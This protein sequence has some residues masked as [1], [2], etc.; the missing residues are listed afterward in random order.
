MKQENVNSKNYW[1]NRF[2]TD[3]DKKQGPDQSR[4]FARVTI[5]NLPDWF[6]RLVT[7]EKLSICDW[8]CAAGDGTDLLASCL[9][10]ALVS[11]VDLS[12]HAIK[13]ANSR[14]SDLKFM[15][16]DWTT[17]QESTEKFD[18]IFSS[19]TLEHF[20]NPFEIL[21]QLAAH[22]R[23][24]IILTLPYRELE[25][26][27]EHF[28]TFLS[29]NIP[30]TTA[31]NFSLV[32]SRVIDTRQITPNYWY[33]EQIVLIYA[34]Q[35]SLSSIELNLNSINITSEF[36]EDKL[37]KLS[38]AYKD[39]EL[40]ITYLK[41]ADFEKGIKLNDVSTQLQKQTASHT[42]LSAQ[43]AFS[44]ETHQKFEQ[45]LE[46]R[47]QELATVSQELESVTQNLL[48]SDA[49]KIHLM[50]EIKLMKVS[51]S[52]RWTTPL[53]ADLQAPTIPELRLSATR[54][55][56][57]TKRYWV[58][59]KRDGFRPATQRANAYLRF[60]LATRKAGTTASSTNSSEDQID[61]SYNPYSYIDFLKSIKVH[62]IN[63]SFPKND[64]VEK[65]PFSIIT[66]LLNEA[67]GVSVF[68]ESLAHQTLIPDEIIIVDGGSTDGTIDLIETASKTLKLSVKLIAS[69]GCSI[70]AGRNIAIAEATHPF[71]IVVDAG[72]HLDKNLCNN[73]VGVFSDY[74]DADLVGGVYQ[75]TAAAKSA[76]HFVP[77]WSTNDWQRFLPSSR[78]LLIRKEIWEKTG[79]Y[80]EFLSKTGEDT[81]FDISYRRHSKLWIFNQAAFV[82][83]NGP[84]NMAA[85]LKLAESYGYGDGESG[86]GDER[87]Y[88]DYKHYVASNPNNS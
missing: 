34:N 32:H 79:G 27:S 41:Q 28:F 69:P 85:A 39:K 87:F 38:T 51:R 45:S 54:L 82:H 1:E 26:D 31:Q 33:G 64:V 36:Y 61:T 21:E 43:L 19:N 88:P 59:L 23:Q 5:E 6:K 53:R 12:P 3:W 60:K 80:P 77:E 49:E 10:R 57:L 16:E 83:W 55:I 42:N 81:L 8:G 24:F 74:P 72:C 71:I 18:A 20:Q 68:I 47:T 30:F 25:R 63:K 75:P 11:G 67:E 13:T 66:T 52:W 46:S 62:A 84:S 15:A 56:H 40:A 22:A 29:G 65:T 86:F 44:E 48:N 17:K 58:L 73:L 70:A 37:S 35:T 9:G 14:Y 76:H 50:S 4:F 2:L 7:N 78:N